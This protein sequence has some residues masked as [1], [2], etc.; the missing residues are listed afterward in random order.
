[1]CGHDKRIPCGT[2]PM[3]GHLAD[4]DADVD[5][6]DVNATLRTVWPSVAA[7]Q[8]YQ[9]VLYIEKEG[10]EPLLEDARI[11]ERF[12]LA[13]LSNKGQSVVAARKFIDWVCRADGGVP[14]FVV[15]DFDKSGFEIAARLTTVSDWAE[16]NDRVTY[17]FENKIN[18]I[19]FGLRLA[20]VDQ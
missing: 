15:H 12:D 8:R 18:V 1:N 13:I 6:F 2:L 20:D 19:D 7:G 5:P 3:D 14:L 16:S 10:F 9:A 17:W 11:A 4:A